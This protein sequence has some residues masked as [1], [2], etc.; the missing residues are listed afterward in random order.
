MTVHLAVSTR[1][2]CHR[3]PGPGRLLTVANGTSGSP[4]EASARAGGW[5]LSRFVHK[6]DPA[7]P[8]WACPPNRSG[9]RWHPNHC[10]ELISRIRNWEWLTR[11]IEA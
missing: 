10:A 2:A 4:V 9:D 5:V 8:R 3:P 7:G 11:H 1:S 6:L